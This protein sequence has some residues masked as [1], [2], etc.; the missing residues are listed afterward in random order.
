[1]TKH[2]EHWVYPIKFYILASPLRKT[3]QKNAKVLLRRILLVIPLFFAVADAFRGHGFSLLVAS[4]TYAPAVTRRKDTGQIKFGQCLSCGAFSSCD[5]RRSRRLSENQLVYYYQLIDSWKII[6]NIF[7]KDRLK[8]NI[9]RMEC[10]T[11]TPAGLVR[12]MNHHNVPAGA[13]MVHHS[14]PRNASAWNGNL[15][16]YHRQQWVHGIKFYILSYSLRKTGQ[17]DA[18]SF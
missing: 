1:M 7:Q 6:N 16:P 14:P 3:R 2:H 9:S 12:Q 4:K 13:V 18:R 5:S 17:K 8:T 11:A 15:L 10:K